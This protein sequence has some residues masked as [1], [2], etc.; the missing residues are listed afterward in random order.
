MLIECFWFCCSG[1]ERGFKGRSYPR[2][3]KIVLSATLTQDPSKLALL[4]LHHPLLLTAGQ[5][6][7][8]LPEK[9]KSFKLVRPHNYYHEIKWYIVSIILGLSNSWPWSF[10]CNQEFEWIGKCLKYLVFSIYPSIL[11]TVQYQLLILSKEVCLCLS[12]VSLVTV[13]DTKKLSNLLSEFS[14]SC[15][16]I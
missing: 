10:H 13:L 15:C 12:W 4:D 11:Y 9:L 8:Q 16:L 6:R 5:R 14:V 1:V 2:L 7:Y 3:V